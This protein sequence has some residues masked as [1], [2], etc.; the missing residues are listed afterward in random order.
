MSAL[1]APQQ[2]PEDVVAQWTDAGRAAARAAAAGGILVAGATAGKSTRLS[3]VSQGRA[4]LQVST[5]SSSLASAG[6]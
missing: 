2:V 1:R 3:C 5:T 6:W 4:A